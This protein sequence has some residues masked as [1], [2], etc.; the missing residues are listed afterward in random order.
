MGCLRTFSGEPANSVPAG[1][2][3]DE[4][5]TVPARHRAC[6]QWRGLKHFGEQFSGF[7]R[8]SFG[9]CDWG[10]ALSF[11]NTLRVFV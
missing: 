1:R 7:G 8:S 2:L 6:P 5:T 11:L 3:K 10:V 4:A 9:I